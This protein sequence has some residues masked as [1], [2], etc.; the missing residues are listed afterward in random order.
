MPLKIDLHVHT[1]YSS[2]AFI[3]P[4]EAVTYAK[5]RGLD[6]IAITDH[7]TMRGLQEF[8]KIKDILIIPGLEVTTSQG[9]VQALNVNTLIKAGKPFAE[10]IDQIHDADGL[11]IAA[12]PTAFFKGIDIKELDQDFDAIEVT[13]A[14]AIPFGHSVRENKKIAKRLGL[15]GTGGSDAHHAPEIGMAYTDVDAESSVEA[16]LKAV[17]NGAVKPFG[18]AIPWSMRLK[19]EYLGFKKILK[20]KL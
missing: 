17:Q 18:R 5:K 8:L 2:D 10:T 11:A 4:K 19:R 20:G 6:G 12:H 3:T 15:P 16:V 1:R 9:H 13:N 7:D 14:S